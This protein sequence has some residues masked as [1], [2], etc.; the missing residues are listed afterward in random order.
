[1][2]H[3][4]YGPGQFVYTLVMCWHFKSVRIV[5]LPCILGFCDV[6]VILS[7]SDMLGFVSMCCLSDTWVL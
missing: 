5:S 3:G 4:S 6:F 1:M 7:L 2:P